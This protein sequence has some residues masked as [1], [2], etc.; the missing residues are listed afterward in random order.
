MKHSLA[1]R[2]HGL[3]EG[4]LPGSVFTLEL[5]GNTEYVLRSLTLGK[6]AGLQWTGV[7]VKLISVSK[8]R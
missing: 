1:G 5:V 4:T 7:A 6:G 8:P 2:Y 3:A